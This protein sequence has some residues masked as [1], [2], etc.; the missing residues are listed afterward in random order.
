MTVLPE[1]VR[2]YGP[3]AAIVLAYLRKIGLACDVWTLATFTEIGRQVGMTRASAT[4][5]IQTL[6]RGRAL[7]VRPFRHKRKMML[8]MVK[9]SD[10]SASEQTNTTQVCR[11]S[12]AQEPPSL[13]RLDS[14]RS[15]LDAVG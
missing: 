1:D 12:I 3:A 4:R 10:A 9:R 8:R 15:I 7:K 5:A 13:E 11:G 2:A 14:V 6:Q